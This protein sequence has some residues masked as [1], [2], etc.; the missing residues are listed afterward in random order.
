MINQCVRCDYAEPAVT[1]AE[2]DQG[3]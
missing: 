3:S 2:P 1:E